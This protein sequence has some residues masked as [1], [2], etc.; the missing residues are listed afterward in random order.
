MQTLNQTNLAFQSSNKPIIFIDSSVENYQSLIEGAEKNAEIIILEKDRSG[1]EQI[2]EALTDLSNIKAL[3]LVSHGSPGSL[4]LGSDILNS[5]N[6]DSFNSLLQQWGKALTKTADILLYGCEVAAGEIGEKFI[7]RLNKIM[8]ANIAA[9][10]NKTGNAA[11][12]GDW[13]LD[14]T[15]GLIET[16]LAFSAVTIENYGGVLAIKDFDL[17]SIFSDDVIINYNNSITD[18][19]QNPFGSPT[20]AL[21]TQSFATFQAG[22]NGNGL[23]DNGLFAANSYHP[24]IQLGYNNTN[25]GNNAKILTTDNSSFTFNVT[26]SPYQKIHLFATGT[27]GS[28]TIDIKFNYSDGSNSTSTGTIGDIATSITESASSYYLINGLDLSNDTTGSSYWDFNAGNIFG[29]GLT[30]D[31]TKT[32]QSITV[33]RTSGTTANTWLNFFGATGEYNNSSPVLNT[34][35][36]SNLTTINEDPNSN[37]GTLVSTFLNSGFTDVNSDPSGISVTSLSNTSDGTW[38]FSNDNGSNWTTFGAVTDSSATL[39]NNTNL[40]RFVPNAN[41]NGNVSLTYRGWD[42]TSGS[43]GQTGVNVSTNGGI[44]AFSTATATSNLSITNIN[45][46]P[47]G[48]VNITGTATQNQILTATNTLADVDGLGTLNYQ[49]QESA[50]NG[51]TWTNISGATLSQTQVGKTVQV[52]VSYTDLLGTAET[53]NSS[54]TS[55]VAGLLN[56]VPTGNVSITGTCACVSPVKVSLPPLETQKAIVAEIEAEQTLVNANRELITRFEK[57]IQTT[58]NRIWGEE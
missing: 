30:P 2:T 38:Q 36:I 55:V 41:F 33:T 31:T 22:A 19:S 8:G 15:I 4:Q 40:L 32:L 43:N 44:T 45:D 13:K 52:K 5:E 3:H 7:R 54:P 11:L 50:D 28:G 56:N 10:S 34:A 27:N 29:L 24:N 58:L 35:N 57:K 25:D 46:A 6:I 23:P 49:W 47:T 48:T 1:V 42:G 37:P 14:K 51:I 21:V 12:G 16:P 26:A 18:T 20:Y 39:L 53:V 9:S 17:S